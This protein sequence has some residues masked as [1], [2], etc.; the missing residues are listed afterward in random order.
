MLPF[1]FRQ[2]EIFLAAAEDCHFALTADR[3]GISQAAVS[4][5]IKKLEKQL[6]AAL[7]VRRVGTKPMLSAYGVAFRHQAERFLTES[8]KMAAFAK[9]GPKQ[10]TDSVRVFAGPLILDQY[11]RPNL[12]SFHRDYPDI[13]LQV[14]PWAPLPK[15]TDMVRRGQ[16]D[17]LLYATQ[18]PEAL[19]LHTEIIVEDKFRLYASQDF[20]AARDASP[21]D[22][23]ALP[24]IGYIIGSPADEMMHTL[25]SGAGITPE[26]IVARTQYYDVVLRMALNGSG[27]ALLFEST[28]ARLEEEDA[29]LPFAVDFPVMYRCIFRKDERVSDAVRTAEQYFRELLSTSGRR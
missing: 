13:M 14:L 4:D 6:G 3:L 15:M 8:R 28:V 26:N 18:D 1:T 12:E 9:N 5:Q 11:I 17:L 27:L 24:F 29:L 21:E 23:S 19:N 25:L 10:E 22:I 20:S 16:A 7:F 2:L